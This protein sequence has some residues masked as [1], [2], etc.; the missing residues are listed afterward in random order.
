MQMNQFKFSHRLALL[1]V[2]LS[3]MLIAG[4]AMGLYGITKAN[5]ALNSVYQDR[6]VPLGQLAEVARV[7]NRNAF[8][9]SSALVDPQ[10]ERTAKNL[11]E[12]E[13]N[14]VSANQQWAAYMATRHTPEEHALATTFAETRDKYVKEALQPSVAALKAND[15]AAAQALLAKSVEP[16]VEQVKNSMTPLLKIQLDVAKAEYTTAEGRYTIIRNLA[17][18]SLAVGLPLAAIFAF[19]LIGS[20]SRALAQAVDVAHA[21]AKGDHANARLL[22]EAILRFWNATDHYNLPACIRYAQSL[23]GVDAGFPR[24]PM[25]PAT[26]AQQAKIKPALEAVL[27]LADSL[28]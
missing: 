25:R 5:D 21:V 14:S 15:T 18:G 3:M 10:P 19:V 11:A 16:L 9:I 27:K 6:T 7:S 28:S 8:L 12:I 20:L 17:V 26:D 24:M 22:H 23:Q 4:A 1:V 2:T 13:A